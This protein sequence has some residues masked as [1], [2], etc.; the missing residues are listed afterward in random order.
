MNHQGIIRPCLKTT[1]QLCVQ[2]YHGHGYTK[3]CSLKQNEGLKLFENTNGFLV[4]NHLLRRLLWKR[5][6]HVAVPN[7]NKELP[8]KWLL[9]FCRVNFLRNHIITIINRRIKVEKTKKLSLY[10]CLGQI[11]EILLII[12]NQFSAW[13][14]NSY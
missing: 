4:R 12:L 1:F 2:Y 9:L 3:M 6:I 8:F 11:R 7:K 10:Y 13:V 5:C 14:F